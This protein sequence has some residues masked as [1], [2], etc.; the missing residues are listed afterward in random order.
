MID[1]PSNIA[2][3]LREHR[4]RQERVLHAALDPDQIPITP[5]AADPVT[6]RVRELRPGDWV[7]RFPAQGR[8]AA[9]DDIRSTVTETV[10]S[11]RW[12]VK[13]RG[14]AQFPVPART[15]RFAMSKIVLD[16]PDECEI[17]VRRRAE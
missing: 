6:I 11:H 5:M 16:V 10:T 1:T 7:E 9:V 4:E 14:R 12:F 13:S 15:V 3:D 2:R 17:V 8:I